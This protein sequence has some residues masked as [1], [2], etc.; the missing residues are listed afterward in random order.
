MKTKEFLNKKNI[1]AIV[2][3]SSNP[4]KWGWKIYKSIKSSGS[5]VYPINPKY[6]EINGAVC[7]PDL[8]S[9]PKNPDMVVTVVPPKITEMVV[10]ECKRLKINKVWMQPGSESGKAIDFCKSNNIEVIYN[11][12]LVVDGL[13]KKF[14]D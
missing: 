10:E 11:A 2:G 7:Y 4:E 5:C 8:K 13:K 1:I 12:C 14:D 6:P 9:L 3:A